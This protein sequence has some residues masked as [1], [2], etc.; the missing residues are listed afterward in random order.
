MNL[1]K[2]ISILIHVYNSKIHETNHKII[3]STNIPYIGLKL[4]I[5]IRQD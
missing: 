5:T 4:P 3:P 2:T 1:F